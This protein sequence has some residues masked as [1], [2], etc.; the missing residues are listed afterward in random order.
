MRGEECFHKP[1]AKYFHP[2][3]GSI[4]NSL[5]SLSGGPI[6]QVISHGDEAK[7]KFYNL[8]SSAFLLNNKT[9]FIWVQAQYKPF[10]IGPIGSYSLM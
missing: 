7:L 4:F 5:I 1:F 8:L 6:S 3:E 2:A 10:A 9:S